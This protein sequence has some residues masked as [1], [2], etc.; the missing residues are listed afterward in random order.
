MTGTNCETGKYDP[1]SVYIGNSIYSVA[2]FA[3]KHALTFSYSRTRAETF[4]FPSLCNCLSLHDV[5]LYI[6]IWYRM[7]KKML[8]HKFWYMD[9][10]KWRIDNNVTWVDTIF[11]VLVA[12]PITCPDMVQFQII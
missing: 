5:F 7:Y 2:M 10:S 12:S 8:I 1:A 6:I 9:G 11:G 4:P 3:S